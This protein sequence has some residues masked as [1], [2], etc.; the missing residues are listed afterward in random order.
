MMRLPSVPAEW[1][2]RVHGEGKPVAAIP[3]RGT[4][5]KLEARFAE[6]LQSK[7]NDGWIRSWRF[8]AV[9]L[10]LAKGAWYTP[11]FIVIIGD[12]LVKF[13]EVKGFRR[14][15]GIVRLKVAAETYPEFRFVL[16]RW[17]HGQWVETEVR[18]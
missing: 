8:E 18:P 3:R 7:M 16:V 11:D 10:R 6:W 2:D 4:M 15:A 1:R 5:N 17:V 14:E 12:C 9:K 13:Y